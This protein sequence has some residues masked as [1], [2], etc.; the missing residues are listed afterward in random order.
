MTGRKRY[1]LRGVPG[2]WR[3]W[4]SKAKRFWGDL[5]EI[6]PDELVAQLNAEKGHAQ[7]TELT[8]QAR[9]AKR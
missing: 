5:Y 7:V 1:A 6:C 3:I 9:A 2:G 4:D 8:R